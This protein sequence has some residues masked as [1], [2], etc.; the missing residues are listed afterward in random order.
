M[1][2][3]INWT[4]GKYLGIGIFFLGI[5]GLLQAILFIPVGQYIINVGTLYVIILLPFGISIAGMYSAQIIYESYLQ[6]K[7]STSRKYRKTSLVTPLNLEIEMLK[8]ILISVVSFVIF[9]WI[10]Y[11]FT[12]SSLAP[13]NCFVVSENAAAIGTLITATIIESQLNPAKRY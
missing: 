8:A 7:T 10:F 13:I 5:M 2:I 9:F 1:P 12:N 4:H 3:K 6:V 11:G